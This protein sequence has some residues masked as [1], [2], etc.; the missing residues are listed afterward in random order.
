MSKKT[1]QVKKNI[2][3]QIENDTDEQPINKVKEIKNPIVIH[4]NKYEILERGTKQIKYIIHL[5]DIHIRR[6]EREQEYKYVFNKLFEKLK[7]LQVNND[8]CLI[9]VGGDIVH[10]KSMLTPFSITL[11]KDFFIGLTNIA[12]TVCIIG[13]HDINFNE[14]SLD[15]I[16]PVIGKAFQTKYSVYILPNNCVYEYNNLILG[17]TNIFAKNVT[18]Y[19]EPTDKIK[20][21]LYHGTIGGSK[22][23]LNFE[24]TEDTNNKLFALKDFKDYNY[25]LFGDIHKFQYLNKERTFMYSGSLI[26]QNRGESLNKGF[27]LLD[28]EKKEPQFIPIHNKYGFIDVIIN[29]DGTTNIS[30][31]AILPENI[32]IKI[33][34]KITDRTAIDK[35]YEKLKNKNINIMEHSENIDYSNFK[36]DT[37]IEIN[38]EQIDLS[39]LRDNDKIINTIMQYLPN[40]IINKESYINKIKYCLTQ[41][42]HKTEFKCNNIK[43]NHL[44]F[45]NM[46]IYGNDNMIDFN[47]LKGICG[48]SEKI[49]QG[50][51]SFI[52]ILL[53]S[54]YGK[55]PR[56]KDIYKLIHNGK[57]TGDTEIEIIANGVT[58]KIEREFKFNGGIKEPLKTTIKTKINVNNEEIDLGKVDREAYIEKNIC[59]YDDLLLSSIIIQNKSKSFAELSS[60]EKQNMICKIFGLDIFEKI[61][62]IINTEQ[63]SLKKVIGSERNTILKKFI[64][65]GSNIET[66]NKNII[67]QKTENEK[68]NEDKNNQIN[69]LLENIKNNEEKMIE[70]KILKEQLTINYNITEESHDYTDDM[71]KQTIICNTIKK[72]YDE[73][74][75]HTKIIE[76]DM[77]NY[78]NIEKENKKFE[79]NKKKQISDKRTKLIKLYQT[80]KPINDKYK[81]Y[82]DIMIEDYEKEYYKD[83][84]QNDEIIEKYTN[85]LTTINDILIP[86]N[87]KSIEKRYNDYIESENNKKE[88]I[89]QI[90][91]AEKDKKEYEKDMNELKDYEFDEK[92]K[93]CLKN[94]LTKQK[95]FIQTRID[96]LTKLIDK[97]KINLKEFDIYLSKNSKYKSIYDELISNINKNDENDKLRNTINNK[98][99]IEQI[100]R[101]TLENRML[102]IVEI[103]ENKRNI[104]ENQNIQQYINNIENEINTI[105]DFK[106]EKYEKYIELKNEYDN[107]KNKL[108]DIKNNFDENNI[109]LQKLQNQNDKQTLNKEKLNEFNI[110]TVTENDI[111][112]KIVKLKIEYQILKDD[113]NKIILLLEKYR[114]VNTSFCIIKNNMDEKQKDLDEYNLIETTLTDNNFNEKVLE[115]ILSQL[116]IIINNISSNIE[117]EKIKF[118]KINDGFDIVKEDGMYLDMNGG[119]RSHQFNIICRIAINMINGN[120]KTNFIIIDELFDNLGNDDKKDN[121][122]LIDSIKNMYETIIIISHDTEIKTTYD[123]LLKIEK[124]HDKCKRLKW[125]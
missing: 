47:K 114:E 99:E 37:K 22:T 45:N 33:T 23:D 24:F 66:I 19:N 9:Y 75:K 125:I 54:I 78:I 98:L 55:C 46:M 10:D 67:K 15:S 95:L 80:I 60:T 49:D 121:I 106:Y 2:K 113:N 110:L 38:N 107:I 72:K 101:K 39:N 84:K 90:V 103:K 58:Y 18:I 85:Q 48:I 7:E 62:D 52:D 117:L 25:G 17:V 87:K 102:Q 92:C 111:A 51:S 100:K 26:Q 20:I 4:E 108:L 76:T 14:N 43:I 8:N 86:K 89:N 11:L 104:E 82:T 120:F 59:S 56:T 44:K 41:T 118:V 27:I 64:D 29:E 96:E 5:G 109:I 3:K 71:H 53:L 124:I 16:T 94:S 21:A 77:N 91:D 50:K 73:Y 1:V 30:E 68:L 34:S 12:T 28:L 35:L 122:K 123:N 79:E 42:K 74:L 36:M 13:N 65:F 116:E 69:K 40:E 63:N 32:D 97:L 70:I 105:N 93:Y 119:G 6:N 88:I 112:D 81:K 31:D 83:K 115:N 57:K 61:R